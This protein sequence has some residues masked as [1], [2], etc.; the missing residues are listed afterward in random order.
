MVERKD[1]DDL[2]EDAINFAKIEAL[3]GFAVEVLAQIRVEVLAQ[4]RHMDDPL[5]A[6][7]KIKERAKDYL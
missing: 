1:S 3:S 7:D 2:Y 6:R 4:I 5:K